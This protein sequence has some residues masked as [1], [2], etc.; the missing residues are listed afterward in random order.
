MKAFLVLLATM[1]LAASDCAFGADPNPSAI[2]EEFLRGYMAGKYIMPR[3]RSTPP[4][5]QARAIDM[6][7]PL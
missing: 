5:R 2:D 4:S 7:P 1:I 6:R 3:S